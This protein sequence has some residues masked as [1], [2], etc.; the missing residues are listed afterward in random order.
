MLT[1]DIKRVAEAA[2]ISAP[3]PL[4]LREIRALFPDAMGIDTIRLVIDQL[5]VEWCGRG[6]ELIQV[7]SGW[8]FQTAPDIKPFIDRLHPEKPAKFSRAVLET[9]AIVAYKQPVTRGEIEAIR[10][11]A[12]NSVVLKQ[13]ED[14]GWV[15]I[16]GHRDVIGRPGLYATTRVFLDDLGL[17][18]ITQLPE[19]APLLQDKLL[20]F[21]GLSTDHLGGAGVDGLC[22]AR[23]GSDQRVDRVDGSSVLVDAEVAVRV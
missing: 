18:S 6:I 13:L 4:T 11:V 8:R 10:G 12:V 3:A 1:S 17:H 15:E 2:L 22:G 16:I 20:A 23:V 9:L 21:P 5:R 7:S 14:R 19:L